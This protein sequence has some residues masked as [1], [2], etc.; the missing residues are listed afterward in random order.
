[1]HSEEVA[2]AD[3]GPDLFDV[4]GGFG[5]FNGF[6]FVLARIDSFWGQ[7]KTQIGNFFVSKYTLFQVDFE[8]MLM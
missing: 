7:C 4:I 1:M 3:K 2:Q 6:E 8:M 5:I